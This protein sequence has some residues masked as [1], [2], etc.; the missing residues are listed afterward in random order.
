VNVWARV[1]KAVGGEVVGLVPG[2]KP[3]SGLI[4]K[5][6][7]A[8]LTGAQGD[9]DLMAEWLD[10]VDELRKNGRIDGNR[11]RALVMKGKMQYDLWDRHGVIPTKEEVAFLLDSLVLIVHGVEYVDLED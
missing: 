3:F 11:S 1:A 7:D 10:D 4:L 9:N 5:A 8:A 2:L 6:L